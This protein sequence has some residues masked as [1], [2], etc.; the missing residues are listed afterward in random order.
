[1]KKNSFLWKVWHWYIKGE[2]HCDQCPYSWEE[3]GLEDADAGCWLFEDGELRDTCRYVR[4]PISKAIVNKKRNMYDSQYDGW[5]EYGRQMSEA[6]D[7]AEKYEQ[8]IQ[9]DGLY[10]T[11]WDI[12]REYEHDM[13]PYKSPW[14]NLKDAFKAWHKDFWWRHLFCYFRR[15]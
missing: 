1:M 15:K 10:D 13:H 8:R 3:R 6:Q 9:Q 7:L 2:Y 14:E 5:E 12:I 11:V 4:N